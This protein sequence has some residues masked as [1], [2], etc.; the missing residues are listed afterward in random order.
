MWGVIERLLDAKLI[1]NWRKALRFRVLQLHLAITAI[2]A[3][4]YNMAK[5]YPDMAQQVLAHVPPELTK[6]WV[7]NAVLGIWLVLG[8]YARLAPQKAKDC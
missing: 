2:A 1:D 8:A 7:V 5:S 3:G 4:V 6:P